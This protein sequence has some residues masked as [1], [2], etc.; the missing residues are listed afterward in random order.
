[1]ALICFNASAKEINPPTSVLADLVVDLMM[2]DEN[3]QRSFAGIA[4]DEMLAAYQ[5]ELEQAGEGGAGRAWFQLFYSWTSLPGR[6]MEHSF[7]I[8]LIS[9]SAHF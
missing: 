6:T 1:M 2:A 8:Q 9:N 5:V 3:A 7:L 4:L